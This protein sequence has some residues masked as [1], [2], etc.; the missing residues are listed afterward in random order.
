MWQTAGDKHRAWLSFHNVIDNY[1]QDGP[2]VVTAADACA[3]MLLA[4]DR[5]GEAADL[6]YRTWQRVDRPDGAAV[7]SRASSWNLLGRRAVQALRAAGRTND[8]DRVERALNQRS[9]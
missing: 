9:E 1:A 6:Y 3:R 8:A 5:A 4:D 7:F 2:M